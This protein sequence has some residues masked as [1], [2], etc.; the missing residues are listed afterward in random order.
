[1]NKHKQFVSE[2]IPILKRKTFYKENYIID[3]NYNKHGGVL[4]K[5]FDIDN[6][7]I[8]MLSSMLYA[9]INNPGI[10]TLVLRK[11]LEKNTYDLGLINS[12]TKF[13]N[14]S[15]SVCYLY[16]FIN[17]TNNNSDNNDKDSDNNDKDDKYDDKDDNNDK[18]SDNNYKDDKD[19]DNNYKDDKDDE[20]NLDAIDVE[21][22]KEKKNIEELNKILY[23]ND[24]NSIIDEDLDYKYSTI[25]LIG[26][27]HH[28]EKPELLLNKLKKYLDIDG[29]IIIKELNVD[30][31]VL[32]AHEIC[33]NSAHV[34]NKNDL[35]DIINKLNIYNIKIYDE[36]INYVVE[37]SIK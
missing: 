15:T 31:T 30:D 17:N 27:L 1:M 8:N 7:D 6:I 11:F 34:F 20:I 2:Y 4:E 28:V 24:I 3:V 16:D 18:D 10:V 21:E 9:S 13:I 37:L 12:Y 14:K 26:V 29:K 36:N 33:N 5:N 23:V 19:G 25:Y 35:V 32:L 22:T